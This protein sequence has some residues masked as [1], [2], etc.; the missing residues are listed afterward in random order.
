VS[1]DTTPAPLTTTLTSPA[2]AT[3]RSERALLWAGVAVPFL[4]YGTILVSAAFYP[5]YNHVTQYASELG[6][7]E[8]RLPAIF[9]I[10]TIITGLVM[11]VAAAGIYRA[12]VAAG[13]RRAFAGVGAVCLALFGVS[14]VLGG[15]FPM[16][17]PRHG[18]FGLGLAMLLA[19]PALAIALWK[20]AEHRALAKFLLADA[21][22]MLVL[23]AIMMGVGALVTRS[24]VGLFQRAYSLTVFPWV[25]VVG[26]A[27]LR[28]T[29]ES[30]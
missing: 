10:G 29:R 11:I 15:W 6:S 30:L 18:G 14:L 27:L 9:N 25:G 1:I 22:I 7:S 28:R 19:P 24:N 17:D 12:S 5:G 4:Y 3:I 2:S 13:A 23:F 21:L 20:R 26:F 16:P 8:A